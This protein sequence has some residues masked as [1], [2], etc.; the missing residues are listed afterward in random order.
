MLSSIVTADM[1]SGVLQE[2]KGLIPIILPTVIGFLAFR[3][4]WS[5]FKG[6]IAGA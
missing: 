6:E 5:F 4:G 2:I 3:K 1:I